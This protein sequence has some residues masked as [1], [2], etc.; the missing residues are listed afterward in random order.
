MVQRGFLEA[1]P[2]QVPEATAGKKISD[3]LSPV[4][5]FNVPN[6]T[7]PERLRMPCNDCIGYLCDRPAGI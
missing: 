1:G 6:R 5:D 4:V 3:R 2:S 7:Q